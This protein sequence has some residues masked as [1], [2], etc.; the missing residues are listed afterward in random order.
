MA[1][2]RDIEKWPAERRPQVQLQAEDD[3][4]I[5]EVDRFDERKN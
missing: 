2:G 5:V 4:E 3:E 1:Y